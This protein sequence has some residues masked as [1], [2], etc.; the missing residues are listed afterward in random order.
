MEV[1][2]MLLNSSYTLNLRTWNKKYNSRR[3]IDRNLHDSY[4]LGLAVSYIAEVLYDYKDLFFALLYYFIGP[5][6]NAVPSHACGI[7]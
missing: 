5:I 2:L 4:H 3:K 7:E 1:Y 6:Q